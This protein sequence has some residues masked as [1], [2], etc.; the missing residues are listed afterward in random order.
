MIRR[1]D[2]KPG[3]GPIQFA[4]RFFR[5]LAEIMCRDSAAGIN[6]VH[7]CLAAHGLERFGYLSLPVQHDRL[8]A[9][10]PKSSLEGVV[11]GGGHL[12]DIGEETHEVEA[13][14]VELPTTVPAE[15]AP[16]PA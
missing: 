9:K 3:Q 10:L 7:V 12:G 16:V 1:L 6:E 8:A 13:E 5:R 11:E 15:P 2:A 4:E 14:P